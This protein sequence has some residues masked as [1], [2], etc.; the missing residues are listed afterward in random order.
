[1]GRSQLFYI[2]PAN[3]KVDI[4]KLNR[5]E[6]EKHWWLGIDEEEVKS[7][8]EFTLE[9]L[10]MVSLEDVKFYS[11]M[12]HPYTLM[13]EHLFRNIMTQNSDI[14]EMEWHFNWE[15]DFPYYISIKRENLSNEHAVQL[16][17]G[18]R[19]S[20]YSWSEDEDGDFVFPKKKYLENYPKDMREP[21][22]LVRQNGAEQDRMMN[23]MMR[24]NLMRTNLVTL[25]GILHD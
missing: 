14:S 2:K 12:V 23:Q 24:T 21:V 7:C 9:K 25:Q 19:N 10:F 20:P 16:V 17:L 22:S 15:G 4:T 13:V 1:M 6:I 5:S 8:K 11:Y 3:I 18:K